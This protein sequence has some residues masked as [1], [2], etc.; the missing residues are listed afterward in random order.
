MKAAI[1]VVIIVLLFAAFYFFGGGDLL[2]PQ[3][4]TTYQAVFL[5]N[6]QVYFGK[7]ASVSGWLVLRDVYY[8]ETTKP[9][10]FEA[11]DT[12]EP[13]SPSKIKLVK[14][15]AELHGPDGEMFIDRDQILFWENMKS[16]SKVLAAIR[17]YQSVTP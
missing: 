2:S 11:G 5:G 3:D 15:G 16:D 7:L 17:E 9:L 6:G 1:I 4:E 8:L 14:L 10:Q 12:P 13:P